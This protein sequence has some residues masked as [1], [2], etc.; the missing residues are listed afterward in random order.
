MIANISIKDIYVDNSLQSRAKNN[1]SIVSEYAL[2]MIEGHQFP[3]VVIFDDGKNKFLADGFHRLAASILNGRDR[4]AADVR[5]G[6]RHD[7]FLFSLQANAAHGLRRTYEDKR[8]CV[9][10]LLN[11]F[12]YADSS[13]REIAK[14]C[15]VSHTFVSKIRSELNKPV[16]ANKFTPASSKHKKEKIK[17]ATLPPQV[18]LDYD[19]RE[20]MLQELAAQNEVL[21]DRLSLQK[22]D[23][24]EEEKE[25]AAQTIANLREENRILLLECNTLKVTR[26]TFQNQAAEAIKQCNI[27]QN[28]I[29]KLNKQI[30]VLQDK[31]ESMPP[32]EEPLPF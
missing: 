26:N 14:L 18:I 3:P 27:Y 30:E 1:D 10:L 31:L 6:T 9:V 22:M 29:K 20:D 32:E 11:D 28:L 5:V 4:I 15:Q 24:T 13:D 16:S 17:V 8:H 2:V 23:A 12:E 25:L 21:T 7:A 19:P